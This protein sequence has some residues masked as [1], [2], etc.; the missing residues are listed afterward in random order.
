MLPE[1]REAVLQELARLDAAVAAKWGSTVDL[2]L[3][4][5]SDRQGIGGPS[6][7]REH[8]LSGRPPDRH[9][10]R[11]RPPR[12]RPDAGGGALARP[13]LPRLGARRDPLPLAPA[14]RAADGRRRDRA[15]DPHRPRGARHRRRSTTTS[16]SC[17]T[18]ASRCCS[19]SPGSRSSSITSLA[20]RCDGERM[21]WGIS[22]AIGL[23]IG[24]ALDAAGVDAD[25]VVA[26]RR[27]RDDGARHARPDPVGRARCCRRRSAGRCSARA[28]PASSGRSSSSRSS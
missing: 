19:S 2:D 28:S 10:S 17:P 15:R 20:M 8:R 7:A 27:V 6:A 14:H 25:V 5:H 11:P 1:R 13:R 3:A 4:G 26:G 9:P 21:G 18:S 16:R 24:I 22:L 23:A 12:G